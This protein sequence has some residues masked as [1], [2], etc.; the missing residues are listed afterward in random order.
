[1]NAN[2]AKLEA[3]AMSKMQNKRT[4]SAGGGSDLVMFS[5]NFVAD[6]IKSAM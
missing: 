5:V 4:R 3:E 2:Y 6:R 1:M